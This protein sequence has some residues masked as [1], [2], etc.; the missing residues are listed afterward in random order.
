MILHPW[1]ELFVHDCKG[2]NYCTGWS[3][4]ETAI[5]AG[6]SGQEAYEAVGCTNCHSGTDGAF[7]VEVPP[8][9]DVDATV[10][11]FFDRS[12][13]RFRAAIAFGLRGISPGD[14]AYTNMPGHYEQLSLRELD[15]VISHVRTLPLEGA[16]FAY[17]DGN[18]PVGTPEE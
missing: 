7:K 1:G 17:A 9:E 8:G 2:V 6:R 15:A 4:T 11:A 14:V 10:A 3:C 12:D 13:D 18:E 5:D 16:A